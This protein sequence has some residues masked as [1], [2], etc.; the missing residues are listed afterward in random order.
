M[1]IDEVDIDDDNY[2][3][4]T[5]VHSIAHNDEDA[6]KANNYIK[7]L[8]STKW[9]KGVDKQRQFLESGTKVKD[10]YLFENIYWRFRIQSWANDSCTIQWK[11]EREEIPATD[12]DLGYELHN[13]DGKDIIV[14]TRQVIKG[15]KCP[16]GYSMTDSF[17]NYKGE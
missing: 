5:L 2:Y 6:I 13:I 4:A 16:K 11:E 10:R 17:F 12:N 7:S 1:S 15:I 9:K 14:K 3:L 8:S